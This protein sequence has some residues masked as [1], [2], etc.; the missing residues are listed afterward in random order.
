MKRKMYLKR[1]F[2]FTLVL[3]L[4]LSMTPVEF[5]SQTVKADEQP[6]VCFENGGLL[7]VDGADSRDDNYGY[8]PGEWEYN[9]P[10]VDPSLSYQEARNLLT[11]NNKK[12]TGAFS[13]AVESA[14]PYSYTNE[15][16]LKNYLTTEL[17]PLRSQG[18]EGTCWAHSSMSLIENYILTNSKKD[19]N[20]TA[21]ITSNGLIP[22][23]NYSELQLAYYYYHD[24]SKLFE[25]KS[26]DMMS[27][28]GSDSFANMGGNLLL[29]AQ[30]MTNGIGAVDETV[31]PYSTVSQFSTTEQKQAKSGI[32]DSKYSTQ[33]NVANLKNAYYINLHSNPDQVKQAIKEN[34][35]VGISFYA[36]NS[37][38][39]SAHNAFY[40]YSNTSTNHA[41]NIVGW[42]DNF[43]KEYFKGS[44]GNGVTPSSNGAWLV[45]NS[46]VDTLTNPGANLFSY[47][48]YFWMSYEDISLADA[49]YVFESEISNKYD[50]TYSHTTNIHSFGTL[51]NYNL[52]NVFE[53]KNQR[54]RIDAVVLQTQESNVTYSISIYSVDANGKPYEPIISGYTETIGTM[55]Y[56]GIYTIPLV[57]P[58]ELSKSQKFAVV[59]NTSAGYITMEYNISYTDRNVASIV[60]CENGESFFKSGYVWKDVADQGWSGFGNFHILALSTNVG[61]QKKVEGFSVAGR[62]TDS[63]SLT[64]DAYPGA[65]SYKLYRYTGTGSYNENA[66]VTRS[67]GLTSTSFTD[68]NVVSNSHYKY[69][70]IACDSSGNQIGEAS[71]IIGTETRLKSS[72]TSL[73]ATI[74]SSE[75]VISGIEA[76]YG[77][78]GGYADGYI[79]SYKKNGASSWID[80]VA[81]KMTVNGTSCWVFN[82]KGLEYGS[83]DYS[84]TPYRYSSSTNLY[85]EPYYG[86]SATGTF[87]VKAPIEITKQPSSLTTALGTTVNFTITAKGTELKYQW[88]T[89]KDS[90][91]TWVNSGMTGYNTNTLTV[92]AA[93]TRNGYQFRCIVTD[94]NGNSVTSNAATLKIPIS[95]DVKITSQPSNV[96]TQ[97]DTTVKFSITATGTGLKYQWQTSKDS[98]KTWVN[99]GMTGYNTNT[100]TVTAV[101]ARNGYQFR[102]VVTDK[103]GGSAT[104]NAATLKVVA[105]TD[106]KITSQPADVTA[107]SGTTATF[108]V[109]ATGTSIKYQW[110]TSKDSGKTWVN[111]SMT[112]YNTNTLSVG[113]VATRNGYQFRCVLTDK[114]GGS[115]TSNAATLKISA[116]SDTKITS[117]PEDVTTPAGTT[118]L[119]SITATGTGLKYQWQTSKY[120]GNTWVNSSMTGYKTN[121][122]SVAA[123]KERNG[124]QFRCIVTDKSGSSVTSN[125]ATLTIGAD[126]KITSQPQ[127]VTAAAGTNVRFEVTATG[128]GLKYQWQTSK[129]NGN[130]WTNSGMVGYNTN[131]LTV[132]AI[133]SRNGYMFRCVITNSSNGEVISN[134]AKL[135]VSK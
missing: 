66:S 114:N 94:K 74:T 135:T 16:Q 29:A 113:V 131:T 79:V 109:V 13:N 101:A 84:V 125:V 64:W 133:A 65:A 97:A 89:S 76:A 25:N 14:Y 40:N 1:T 31:I 19:Q 2:V 33:S 7:N 61:T 107:A 27:F 71:R 69:Y 6:E 87:T 9:V 68:S 39:N 77:P 72:D 106:I 45:R 49:A 34:H 57:Q 56:P 86:T 90:G 55:I 44:N 17:P 83:Y 48:G 32:N 93:A 4:V 119:F 100:L 110:Q 85:G 108:S 24:N 37:Y 126:I 36:A 53:V 121:T 58:V 95:S 102:C 88:Q 91:K 10:E 63:I 105:A 134:S 124:Y 78:F 11:P 51:Q 3:A 96:T 54:E 117:Q 112:G 130:T 118:A 115:V 116:A 104:S 50:N 60:G 80:T 22:G 38:Y 62:T 20:G 35:A 41:V 23:I 70:V 8:I 46:W 67:I 82:K 18:S 59:V 73:K 128:T 123:V 21:S 81:T 122:L 99:S 15:T 30:V 75:A 129:D 28:N 42:D 47:Y 111:S 26:G 132:S 43:P 52:A 92:T 127:D 103:S 120:G 12:F 5:F 98:G